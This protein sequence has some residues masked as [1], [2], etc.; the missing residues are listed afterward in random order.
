MFSPVKKCIISSALSSPFAA[1]AINKAIW[2]FFVVA[3]IQIN[4]TFFHLNVHNS[5]VS[6]FQSRSSAVLM[7]VN[8]FLMSYFLIVLVWDIKL[9]H[10]FVP[11]NYVLYMLFDVIVVTT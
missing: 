7:S 8:V 4:D 11:F 2:A 3:E 6:K 5:S 9:I 1:A 10:C